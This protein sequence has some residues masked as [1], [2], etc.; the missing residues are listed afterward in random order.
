MQHGGP[1]NTDVRRANNPMHYWNKDNFEGLAAIAE[2]LRGDDFLAPIAR[3]CDLRQKGLR[4][5]ALLVLR[6]FVSASKD[7]PFHDRRTTASRLLL[8]WHNHP[9]VHQLLPQPLVDGFVRP[10]LSEW[11]HVEP[12]NAEALRWNGVVFGD[13]LALERAL[14]LEPRDDIARRA[15]ITALLND[16]EYASH[17]LVEGRFI[18]E[19]S[20]AET[21][22]GDAE[23]LLDGT[24]DQA[25]YSDL[26]LWFVRL[27]SL[28]N[29][30]IEYRKT[31]TGDFPEW[32]MRRGR[33]H[34]WP[35]IV[36]YRR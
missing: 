36:Y 16:V 1:V 2:D 14:L 27:R 29:D 19:E 34:E 23:T 30:W 17:H 4:R 24:F 5:P 8:I 18:G 31:P 32:C 13:R 6:E 33:N 21:T 3:Y 26:R 10:T 11:S 12:D 22:L 28:L 35:I 25:T 15:L 20:V 9:A 7:W